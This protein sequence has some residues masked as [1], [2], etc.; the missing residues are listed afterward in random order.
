M[1][2]THF[3][4]NH[5]QFVFSHLITYSINCLTSMIYTHHNWWF[6]TF[7]HILYLFSWIKSVP[8]AT[9]PNLIYFTIVSM[10]TL[11]QERDCEQSNSTMSSVRQLSTTGS[12]SGLLHFV[13]SLNLDINTVKPSGGEEFM[14]WFEYVLSSSDRILYPFIY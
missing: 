13:N 10:L 1:I 4:L 8:I 6:R 14:R 3:I 2:S 12:E 7:S 11:V 9:Y 5:N